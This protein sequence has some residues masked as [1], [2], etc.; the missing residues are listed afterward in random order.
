MD[1]LL[2]KQDKQQIFRFWNRLSFDEQQQLL[3][4]I[5]HIDGCFLKKQKEQ[6][7]HKPLPSANTDL[8]P[9]LDYFYSGRQEDQKKGTTSIQA[10]HV[11]CLILAGGQGTRLEFPYPK[12]MYPVSVIQKKSLF[13]LFA[14]KVVAASKRAGRLLPLAIMTSPL[15]DEVTREFFTSQNLFGL[16]PEQLSFFSQEQLPLLDASGHLFLETSYR[17]AEGPNG[18]GA[19]LAEF[20]KSGIWSHWHSQGVRDVNL[21]LIDNPLADPFDAELIGFHQRQKVELTLK[22]TEKREAEEKVGVLVKQQ[23][24]PRIIEY[25]EI[26]SKERQ[27]L[28][29]DGRLKHRCANLSLFCF[30]MS[31]IEKIADKAHDLPLHCVWKIT[32]Y[33]N[34]KGVS[35]QPIEPNAWK[36]ELFIFDLLKYAEQ[37]ATLV[38]PRSQCFAPLKNCSGPDSLETV[39]AALQQRDR[40]IIKQLTGIE[41]PSGAFELAADFYYPPPEL[42]AQWQH[43]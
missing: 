1:L 13:Q 8:E 34:E 12:G 40:E 23:G 9:F 5:S 39:Q 17:I 38:Y 41:P 36:C 33:T 37:V 42:L 35:C 31:F 19:C 22:C 18:N 27:A 15:N 2:D 21:V 24:R 7:L 6:I 32:K 16:A 29:S 11:G 4:Q 20:F 25:S 30:S 26:S 3:D 14:E 28:A 10:G 43:S